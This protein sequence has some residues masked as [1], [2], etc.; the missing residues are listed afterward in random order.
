MG[1][2]MPDAGDELM[3]KMNNVHERPDVKTPH[4]LKCSTELTTSDLTQ[5]YGS[6]NSVTLFSC[7]NTACVWWNLY[8]DQYALIPRG[9][10]R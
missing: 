3:A 9:H 10:S 7:P 8:V 1:A 4:C 5:K 2:T 6:D